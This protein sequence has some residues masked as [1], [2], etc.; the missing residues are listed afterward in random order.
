MHS[1]PIPAEERCVKVAA[2]V[3]RLSSH[4]NRGSGAPLGG[5]HTHLHVAFLHPLVQQSIQPF[6]P[7]IIEA[8]NDVPSLAFTNEHGQCDDDCIPVCRILDNCAC[9]RNLV[10]TPVTP[11]PLIVVKMEVVRI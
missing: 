8:I 9:N 1:A 6:L 10:P 4:D 3:C 7:G 11:S 2:R 5:F